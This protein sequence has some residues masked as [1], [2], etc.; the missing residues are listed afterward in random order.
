M[1]LYSYTTYFFDG[2]DMKQNNEKLNKLIPRIKSGDK[3][4]FNE[5]YKLTSGQLYFLILKIVQNEQDAEDILQESY[6]K[7]FEKIDEID[8][9]Q[10]FISW[11]YQIAANKS[12]D[13][14]RRKNKVFFESIESE[15]FDLSVEEN[16]TFYPEEN[17]DKDELC[18]QV[19]T[20]I[21]ELTAEK[22]ACVIMKYYAQMSVNEIA[23]SLDVP[24]STVKNRLFSARKD[25]KI[26]FE[27]LGKAALYSAAPIGIII[28]ALNR[29]SLSICAAFSASTASAGILTCISNT[30]SVSSSAAT[31]GTGVA[32]KLGAM[33]VAQKIAAGTVAATII[34]GSTAGTVAVIKHNSEPSQTTGIY[35]EAITTY[36]QDTS[37]FFSKELYL[38]ETTFKNETEFDSPVILLTTAQYSTTEKS[39]TKPT[40][41]EAVSTTKIITTQP[42]TTAQET[43][44]QETT[45]A[46][47]PTE[48]TTQQSIL[49]EVTTKNTTTAPATIIIEITDYDDNIVDTITQSVEAGTNLTWD[50]LIE[51]V[52]KKGYEAMAGVYGDGVDTVAE[53]GKTY[54]FTAE[55]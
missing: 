6:I 1:L 51:L 32:A 37:E 7:M 38:E 43:T 20:A 16:T 9:A 14:L 34:G 53:E 47:K 31:A 35:A 25:L 36:P 29:S 42:Q 3:K 11:F 23:E 33:S 41:T 46:P 4:A 30:A 10:N 55:L 40:Q 19:I 44:K 52:S 48:T 45:T 2:D 21:D 27:K 28:W 49:I 26:S 13:L 5:L 17:I 15:T 54:T 22:R 8:P 39:T 24:I 50:Y 12:K 18:T